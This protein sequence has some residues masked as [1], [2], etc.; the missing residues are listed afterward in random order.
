[1]IVS[2]QIGP[3]TIFRMG[4]HIAAKSWTLY[5]TH[6]FLLGGVMIDTGTAAVEREWTAR[7]SQLRCTAVVNT[8]HHEDHTGNNRL[9]QERFGAPVYAHPGTI[10]YLERPERIGMQLY[11]RIVW[12]EPAA[13][14]GL[15]LPQSIPAGRHTLQAIPAPGHCPDHVCLFEPEN[16]W[17]FSGDIFCG[18]RFDY[19]RK[20]EDY[21]QI[22]ESL[23]KLSRLDIGTMFCGFK[24]AIENGAEAIR[25]KIQFMEEL[26]DNV[27]DLYSKGLTPREIRRKLLGA[28]TGMCFVT[29]GHYSKQ[30]TVDDI[31]RN[32]F[33]EDRP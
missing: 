4:K 25:S 21:N 19:L 20:D 18:K 24:G 33:P 1:M 15:P 31:I 17:L 29:F 26:R 12:K 30:N 6:A 8:H 28:E 23:K 7:F 32:E 27:L 22:L 14:H 9:F 3:V 13:S 11:R 5:Y 10:P 16:G 2:S